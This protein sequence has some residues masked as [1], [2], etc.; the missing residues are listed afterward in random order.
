MYIYVL[1]IVCITLCNGV[2][3][4]GGGR[5]GE[6]NRIKYNNNKQAIVMMNIYLSMY[7]VCIIQYDSYYSFERYY[8]VRISLVK[9][10]SF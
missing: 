9:N 7:Y 5:N 1:I 6:L 2:M 8:S 10:F 4:Y 3:G